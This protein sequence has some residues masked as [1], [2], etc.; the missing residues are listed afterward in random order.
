MSTETNSF[1][2]VETTFRSFSHNQGVNYAQY[3]RDYHPSLYQTILDHHR[4]TGGQFNAL[5]DVGCGPGTATRNLAPHFTHA[6]GVDAS[7]GMIATARL[8]PSLSGNTHF[9]VSTV[10]ELGQ[11]PIL[12]SIIPAGSV[13]LIT[14][15]NAAHWFDMAVFWDQAAKLLKPGGSVALWASG[16]IMVHPEL[17][18][19]AA[20]IQAALGRVF[21]RLDGYLLPGNWL[22]RGLYR[23][24]VM[25]WMV[26]GV[27][28]EFEE[29]SLFRKEWTGMAEVDESS[30]FAVDQPANLKSLELVLGTTSPVVRWREAHPDEA[31]TESDPVRMMRREMEDA[32]REAGVESLETMLLKGGVEGVLLIVKKKNA[33]RV[34]R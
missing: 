16:S 10:E 25:P 2:K 18:P 33:A 26:P 32:L 7:E 24:L 12:S 9:E 34:F 29:G 19:G 3:R 20:G 27:A 28:G 14:S 22:T 4:S 23:D 1:S 6:F 15:A 5:L 31:G 17:Q 11:N 30:M 21:E 13:D 8:L